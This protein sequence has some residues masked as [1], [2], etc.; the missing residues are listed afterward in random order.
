MTARTLRIS[1]LF[2]L[3]STTF[4]IDADTDTGAAAHDRIGDFALI[5]QEGVFHQITRYGYKDALVLISQA[6]GCPVIPSQL[7][8]LTTLRQK[9][10][11]QNVA[12]LMIN[13]TGRDSREALQAE[14]A[15]YD[16]DYPILIDDTQLVAEALGI[17]RVGELIVIEPKT[18]KLIFKG[19]LDERSRR[20][21]DP[22]K[23]TPLND[24]L[25]RIVAAE[26]ATMDTVVIDVD[27]AVESGC[28]QFFD[29][30]D[31]HAG[32]TPDYAHDVA[33]ILQENCV[34]C[35]REGGIGPFAM[36]SYHM[37]RGWSHMI[38]EVL[39]TRRMPPAQVDPHIGAFSNARHL[40]DHD[41]QTL[42][43][44]IDQGAPRGDGSD[45]LLVDARFVAD[46]SWSLG[47]PDYIVNIPPQNVPATGVLDYRN[48]VIDLPFETDKWIRAIHFRPGDSKVM[49]HLLS[50][51]IP[52][53][54]DR[55]A[56]GTPRSQRRFLEGYAPGK[57]DA[58]TYPEN[59]GVYI[60]QGHNL[61]VQLHYT[62]YGK[63]T[64]D[65]TRIGLYFHDTPPDHEFH[66]KS[67][68]QGN[69]AI[70][71]GAVEYKAQQQFVFEK[72]IVLYGLRPHMHYRGK[73]FK[74]K[75]IYPDHTS[76]ELLSVP[77]Y[78]FNW[79]PTYRLQKP[80]SLPAGSRVVV[81]GAFDNSEFNPGN[82]DP[83]KE[84][85]W[86]AQSWDEMFIGYFAYHFADKSETR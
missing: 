39:M 45:P 51:I 53:D 40:N 61:R 23:P 32:N 5:D 17:T 1:L 62:T 65:N 85:T 4:S 16:L 60:P 20:R 28:G 27:A 31:L 37:V 72:D 9:W 42:V 64:V 44:W 29:E 30:G 3:L 41:L 69:L 7:P 24:A 67:V 19:P 83:S 66:N 13:S 22:P 79:Q 73:H 50:Y 43:H 75:V 6:N 25:E 63:E 26:T 38:R 86:G 15:T 68:V 59:A 70:P 52:P 21:D 55:T 71:P 47:E 54:Y 57:F 35:H 34:H 2:T 33:P 12:F 46:P 18:L 84:I 11:T 58:M 49:H 36:D 76:E 77:N 80:K 78:N 74:F 82:P 14:A 48:V 8:A 56:D 10:E 81:S